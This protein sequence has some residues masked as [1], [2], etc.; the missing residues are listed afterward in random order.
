MRIRNQ[1]QEEIK[2]VF[3]YPIVI[4]SIL[5]DYQNDMR[6]FATI[7]FVAALKT[8]SV[9]D[10]TAKA[11]SPLPPAE[12]ITP[13]QAL[14]QQLSSLD[15]YHNMQIPAYHQSRSSSHEQQQRIDKYYNFLKNQIQHDPRYSQLNPMFS[16]I[17][18][19]NEYFIEMPLIVGTR[20]YKVPSLSLYWVLLIA[21]IKG[22]DLSNGNNLARIRSMTKIITDKNYYKMLFDDPVLTQAMGETIGASKLEKI[23][24]MPSTTGNKN[25]QK[26]I[27][28]IS[29]A[30]RQTASFNIIGNTIKYDYEKAAKR[31]HKLTD[32][33]QWEQNNEGI[34]STPSNIISKVMD[35]TIPERKAKYTQAVST[36]DNSLSNFVIPQ[37]YS[38]YSILE[39]QVNIGNLLNRFTE[40]LQD[41]LLE[42]PS[43]FDVVGE[44]YANI[45]GRNVDIDGDIDAIL[46]TFEAACVSL[47][48]LN[49]YN[50]FRGS[51]GEDLTQQ[52][53]SS[54]S[55]EDVLNFVNAAEK[56]T[57]KV[58]PL[59]ANLEDQLHQISPKSDPQIRGPQGVR[60]KIRS[61]VNDLFNDYRSPD[62][63]LYQI[64]KSTPNPNNNESDHNRLV[65]QLGLL[66][67]ESRIHK[68]LADISSI[69][70]RLVSDLIY[71]FYLYSLFNI[72]CEYLKVIKVKIKATDRDVMD[73]PNY[74]LVIPIEYIQGIWY[75]RAARSFEDMILDI[76]NSKQKQVL[77]PKSI[78]LTINDMM[79]SLK[80]PNLIVVDNQKK[81]I[82]YRFMNQTFPIK[83][84]ASTFNSFI[85]HQKNVL[86][87]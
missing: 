76:G 86:T 9:L 60:A 73:F 22:L 57:A 25:F 6:D 49:V 47:R 5:K 16:S 3:V 56:L 81:E 71:F 61:I 54:F 1:N 13:A 15:I 20:P 58:G 50:L 19:D 66:G 26:K 45:S 51:Y 31:L 52:T 12:V 80:I 7:N 68:I 4:D 27:S 53:P 37:I 44:S 8:S 55:G 42:G 75:A 48:E 30:G 87:V 33:K 23:A 69:G 82:Y 36:F 46:N 70:T 79:N 59:I 74:T 85:K 62:G 32:E 77:D 65:Q 28:G 64:Y 35:A 78:I 84:S 24:K 63:C 10:I 43:G 34:I 21:M 83:I 17:D 72:L 11:I 38:F 2:L 29:Y 40:N 14:N 18:V 39:S 41:K 67:K